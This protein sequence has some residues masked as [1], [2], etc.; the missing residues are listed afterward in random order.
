[1]ERI[2]N[3]TISGFNE[4]LQTLQAEKMDIDFSL[5]QFS[6]TD[7]TE[8][9]GSL[10]HFKPLNNKTYQPNGGTPLFDAVVST[11]EALADKTEGLDPKKTSISVVIMTDG[12][13]NASREHD[14]ECLKKLIK[15]LTKR[16]NWTFAFMGANQDA[17]ANAASYGI[18]AGNT[19]SWDST[20]RGA[21]TAFRS[22]AHGSVQYSQAMMVN[23]SK[24]MPM[25]SSSFFV[26]GGDRNGA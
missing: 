4:Y 3:Q 9:M 18:S 20:K 14:A 23:A 5:V 12:E 26:D 13:E 16:G 15:E 19:M 22:L 10:K 25:A 2:K 6:S 11:I 21:I 8:K 7:K 24:G 17:W 1:M